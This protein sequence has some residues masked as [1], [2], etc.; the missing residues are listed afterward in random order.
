MLSIQIGWQ[1]ILGIACGL[2]PLSSVAQ[3]KPP[4]PQD[5][6]LQLLVKT[7]DP[8]AAVRVVADL[9]LASL[10][11]LPQQTLTTHTPWFKEPVTFTGPLMRD[12]LAVAKLQ[13]TNLTAVAL[14]EYKAKIPFSDAA[15]FDVILAH[16]INGEQM[17]AKNKGP[18]FIVYPYDSKKE[19][20]T[21]LYYQRSVWQLKALMVE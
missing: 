14:D 20:Q 12:V 3:S 10:K 21:V 6:V 19:L 1:V 17:T 4:A 18:L 13:G 9:D 16:S 11:K 5:K 8:K 2:V 15:R 7:A